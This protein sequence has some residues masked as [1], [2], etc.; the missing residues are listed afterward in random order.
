[1]HTWK[2]KHIAHAYKNSVYNFLMVGS[3]DFK[4]S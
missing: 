3:N 1:M 2:Y 4:R